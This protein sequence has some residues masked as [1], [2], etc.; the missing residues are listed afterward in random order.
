M[1]LEK[2]PILGKG[3]RTGAGTTPV[4]FADGTVIHFPIANP[5]PVEFAKALMRRRRRLAAA[6][7]GLTD[8][9]PRTTESIRERM[10]RG[11]AARERNSSVSIQSSDVELTQVALPGGWTVCV[12]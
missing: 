4:R 12:Q 11:P 2:R 8:N 6:R 9:P 10:A 3:K 5:D 1:L 7:S